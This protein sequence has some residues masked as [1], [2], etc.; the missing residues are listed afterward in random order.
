MEDAWIGKTTEKIFAAPIKMAIAPEITDLHMPAEGVAHNLVLVTI[1]KKY[2]GQG[3]KVLG[4]LFGAGQMMLSKYIV[5]L[6]NKVRA[7]DYK[8][9]VAEILRNVK[10]WTDTLR[11]N[12]P[13]DVLDHS[14]NTFSF[15]GKL[16][17][18][19]TTKMPEEL[20]GRPDILSA[21]KPSKEMLK[22]DFPDS[23]TFEIENHEIIILPVKEENN[24][25]D[26]DSFISSLPSFYRSEGSIVVVMDKK[27]E[28]LEPGTLLW[29]VLS[30]TDPERDIYKLT[31]GGIVINACSKF[32]V[33]PEFP[34][35]WPN[36]VCSDMDTIKT[37]DQQWDSYGVGQS[38]AS[39]S[40]MLNVLVSEGG[41]SVNPVM[42][43]NKLSK[44]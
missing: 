5:V 23:R 40:L 12:G 24:L 11:L 27:T 14:S 31:E 17:I 8:A 7:D 13:L 3:M 29:L 43:K 22:A 21:S 26:I 42:Q 36:I 10:M 2:P 34:R 25:F 30:N 41:A 6:D 4:A 39:P 16:G 18:D 1:D 28:D 19:A 37:V 32:G 35:E 20:A 15:G 38:H 44:T 9:V 33:I